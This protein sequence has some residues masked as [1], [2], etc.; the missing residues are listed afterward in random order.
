VTVVQRLRD[1]GLIE[2]LDALGDRVAALPR[3]TTPTGAGLVLRE[4][5]SLDTAR[6]VIVLLRP[7]TRRAPR[8]PGRPGRRPP[9]RGSRRRAWPAPVAAVRSYRERA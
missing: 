5:A 8:R 6:H 3:F 4:V 2:A 7:D 1:N 9:R